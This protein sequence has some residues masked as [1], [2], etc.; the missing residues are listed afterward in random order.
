MPVKRRFEPIEVQVKRGWPVS[1]RWNGRVHRVCEMLDVWVVQGQW[2][3]EEQK[4]VFFRVRTDR[5]VVEL[6]R[7]GDRWVLTKQMD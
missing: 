3:G 4:R 6:Y 1:F 2:W 7:S 5:C